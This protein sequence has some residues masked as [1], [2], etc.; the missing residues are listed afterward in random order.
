MESACMRAAVPALVLLLVTGC[1]SEGPKA[2]SPVKPTAG[3]AAILPVTEAEISRAAM[4]AERFCG[5]Y[6][7][8]RYD[9][10]PQ[11]Y[12]SRLTP[13]AMPELLGRLAKSMSSQDLMIERR[14]DREISEASAHVIA[15]RS[16]N[17]NEIMFTVRVEQ[18][19]V[20]SSKRNHRKYA[21]WVKRLSD[22]GDWMIAEIEPAFETPSGALWIA[23]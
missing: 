17:T 11:T 1:G 3:I 19:I 5:A 21:V 20:G 8:W 9:E 14:M 7:T 10:D 16:L 13:F 22:H 15:V 6:E 4:L 23:D 12:L 18:R 2:P